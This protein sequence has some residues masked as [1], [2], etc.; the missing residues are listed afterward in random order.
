MQEPQHE[1]PHKDL[2]VDIALECTGIFSGARTR[3]PAH[4]TAGAKRVIISAPGD[5]R[6]C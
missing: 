4:L 5:E 6:R 1:L 3:P 2:G